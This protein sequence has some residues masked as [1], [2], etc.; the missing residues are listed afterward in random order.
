MNIILNANRVKLRIF[1]P[2]ECLLMTKAD[3]GR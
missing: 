3:S 2:D 1:P